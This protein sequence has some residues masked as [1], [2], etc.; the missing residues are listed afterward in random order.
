VLVISGEIEPDE[1]TGMLRMR[2]KEVYD[3]EEARAKFT[4]C[5]EI[6]YCHATVPNGF[7]DMLKV[8]LSEHLAIERGCP[9]AVKYHTTH[10]SGRVLL[11]NS[12]RVRASDELLASLARKF[13]DQ[14]IGF[15]FTKLEAL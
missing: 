12:W 9:V 13:G 3:M 15:A 2:A 4:R 14:R 1:Y 5:L 10:A 6:D 8:I 7:S 11:G